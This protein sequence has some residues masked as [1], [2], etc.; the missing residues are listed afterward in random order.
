M[1]GWQL[2][3][4]SNL[5]Y[6]LPLSATVPA[7]GYVTFYSH[8]LG[9]ALNNGADTLTLKRP[10]NSIADTFEYL[11][12]PGYDESWCRLADG[13]QN[14]SENCIPSPNARNWERGPA[15]PLKAKIY[16]A[17]R[18]THNAWVQ[19]SGQVTA[20]PGVLGQRA[21]Y[22]QD[23]TA[24]ILVYLPK[25]HNLHLNKGDKVRVEGNLKQFR[26]EFEIVVSQRSKVKFVEAGPPPHPLP[27]ETTMMLEPYEGRLV[28]LTGRAT[29]FKGRTVFWVDDGTDPAKVYIRTT[30]GIK[31]PFIE[32]GTTVTVV[33]IVSQYSE[34]GNATRYDYRLLPREQNDLMLAQ[35]IRGDEQSQAKRVAAWPSLLPETGS[36]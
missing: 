19:V 32:P 8:Q 3:D 33:G 18:L 14:W 25:N 36:K 35:E 13:I 31:K 12:S 30:T 22:V 9:F 17:K 4:S 27:I 34:P 29:R 2:S 23:E 15:Q 10:D 28:M 26:G 24:G 20:P 21:M 16:D 7:G 5:T 11:N 1:G 6:S